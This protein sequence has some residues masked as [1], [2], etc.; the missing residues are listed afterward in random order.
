LYAKG[1]KINIKKAVVIE[2][3]K[4]YNKAYLKKVEASAK[5]RDGILFVANPAFN[6]RSAGF[7][8]ADLIASGVMYGTKRKDGSVD[9]KGVGDFK[10]YS[11]KRY[12]HGERQCKEVSYTQKFNEGKYGTL[13]YAIIVKAFKE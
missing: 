6:C 11:Y 1:A 7:T 5:K 8:K 4:G 10:A 13:S 3:K 12:M 9:I 2:I